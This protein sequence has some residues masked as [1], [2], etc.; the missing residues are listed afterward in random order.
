MSKRLD[1]NP[2]REATVGV[3]NVYNAAKPLPKGAKI[4][5]LRVYQVFPLSVAS[6]RVTHAPGCQIPQARDSI[7]LTRAVLGT[8]PVE[9]DGSAH[10][11]VPS[12]KE[13]FF[14]VL[15]K[16]GLAIMSMRSGTHFQPGERTICQGCHEPKYGVAT[17]PSRKVTM[18]MRRSPSKLK[19]EADGT[20]PFSYPR[21]IQPVLDK[22]CVK[23][24]EK[25]KDHK[26]P[27]KR[28]L[29]L[30][31]KIVRTTRG[32]YMNPKTAYFASYINLAPKYGFYD[33]GG[34]SFN[35][36]K[37]YRTTAGEFGAKASK[38]YALLKKGHYKV[39]LSPEE[40][41]RIVVWL[42]SLSPFYGVYE[43]EGGLAQLR[44]EIAKPTLE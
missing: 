33:Y 10:F 5:S 30:D 23:C 16:N 14:Q 34:R 39:K 11:T 2:P 42:D 17:S 31:S 20:N 6:A 15:D 22:H 32:S 36:P 9:K 44:G 41:R 27:A 38:L 1:A 24:H 26:D 35:D 29:P 13:L 25:N 37:W 12:G 18:A 3:V 43:K 28:T 40:M 4:T 21:L 8:V 19:P 7:N